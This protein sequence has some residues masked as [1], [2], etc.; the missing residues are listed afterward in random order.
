[1]HLRQYPTAIA[2]KQL[3]LLELRQTTRRVKDAIALRESL[4]ESAIAFDPDLKND[5]QRKAK[6]IELTQT[7]QDLIELTERL[8]E[9][10]SQQQRVEIDL[11]L[12]LN[13]FA[14]AKLEKRQTIAQLETEAQLAS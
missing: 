7:D 12:L 2:T 10:D 14:I 11:N 1:M 5:G 4:I 9:L 8:S 3:E 6:R 13:K